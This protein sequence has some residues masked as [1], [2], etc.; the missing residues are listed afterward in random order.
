M[1]GHLM[2]GLRTDWGVARSELDVPG[3][4]YIY[5]CVCNYLFMYSTHI[6][7]CLSVYLWIYLMLG[8]RTDW[9]VARSE[10]DVPRQV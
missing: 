1:Y 9:G 4:V 3:Q 6:Y 8:L 7:I 5:M 2:L 10:L